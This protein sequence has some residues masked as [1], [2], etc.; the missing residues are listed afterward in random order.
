MPTNICPPPPLQTGYSVIVHIN[1]S[2]KW[3]SE[4]ID[5]GV[6]KAFNSNELGTGN[7]KDVCSFSRKLYF[8]K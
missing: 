3:Y 6:G 5:Q 2:S 4:F 8:L 1:L 7:G